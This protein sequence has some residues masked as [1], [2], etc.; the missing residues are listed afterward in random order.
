MKQINKD[1]IN[2][3]R[4]KSGRLAYERIEIRK[5]VALTNRLIGMAN[6]ECFTLENMKS[7]LYNSPLFI[8]FALPYQEHEDFEYDE[9]GNGLMKEL[10]DDLKGM[11]T[12]MKFLASALKLVEECDYRWNVLRILNENPDIIIWSHSEYESEY[13]NIKLGNGIT[14]K[15]VSQGLGTD[16]CGELSFTVE[17]NGLPVLP[18]RALV[19]FYDC[20]EDILD[21]T[22]MYDPELDQWDNFLRALVNAANSILDDHETYF[23]KNVIEDGM[24]MGSKMEL[25]CHDSEAYYEELN[26]EVGQVQVEYSE[27]ERSTV[28]LENADDSVKSLYELYEIGR[29]LTC[30]M[31]LAENLRAWSEFGDNFNFLASVYPKMIQ[32][33]AEV[34]ERIEKA[35]EQVHEEVVEETDEE[36]DLPE[37][38]MQR[39]VRDLRYI[40]GIL[41]DWLD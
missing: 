14:I 29:K 22:R 2:V 15:V 37:T 34:L 19:D 3:V 35:L 7:Y 24:A 32:L 40:K 30:A 12:K 26:Y 28:N 25:L 17:K 38:E 11:K 23:R 13:K 9:V 33:G 31:S 18:Y 10:V 5:S 39:T 1:Y 4:N 36:N 20:S 8:Y 21:S 41:R 27:N 16:Y 6:D